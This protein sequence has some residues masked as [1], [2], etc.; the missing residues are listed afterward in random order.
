MQGCGE[1]TPIVLFPPAVDVEA[2][3]EPKP[4]PPVEIATDEQAAL[5]YDLALEAWGERV[6][7]AGVRLCRWFND[8]GGA[9]DCN[10]D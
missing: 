8:N 9:F 1:P 4:L 7:S 2:S 3:T 5:E 6:Q 10:R